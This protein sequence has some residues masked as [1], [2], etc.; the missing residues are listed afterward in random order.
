MPPKSPEKNQSIQT[1]GIRLDVSGINEF[2]SF[3]RGKL[4]CP[5]VWFEG[6]YENPFMETRIKFK[7]S[8]DEK[9]FDLDCEFNIR[10]DGVDKNAILINDTINETIGI[11]QHSND[12]KSI[13]K[14]KLIATP[15][16]S[17]LALGYTPSR[18]DSIIITTG[19]NPDENDRNRLF[20]PPANTPDNL[21]MAL[22]DSLEILEIIANVAAR[23]YHGFLPPEYVIELSMMKKFDENQ[24][25]TLGRSALTEEMMELAG[26]YEI[27]K[28]GV[29]FAD[30]GGNE[31]AK[32]ELEGLVVQLNNP[33]LCRK[34]AIKP[35]KGIVLY[36]PTGTGKTLMVKA[37]ATQTEARF[38]V[39]NSS[40]INSKWFGES[41]KNVENIFGYANLVGGKT[42]I[43]LDELDSI[44]PK[45]SSGTHEATRKVLNLL[46][47]KIDGIEDNENV[48]IVASTNRI[49]DV[50]AAFIRAGRLGTQIKVELPDIAAI[51]QIYSIHKN[52]AEKQSTGSESLFEHLD[53]D[54]LARFSA[55]FSGADIAE[56]I[57]RTLRDKFYQDVKGENPKKINTKDLLAQINRY[58]GT[59][60]ADCAPSGYL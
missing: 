48:I 20:V 14:Y 18:P 2:D 55:G 42:I 30:V 16:G 45:R 37:L 58:F 17:K 44:A 46:L 10:I 3:C 51:K 39:I 52:M 25:L 6:F 5:E 32:A 40:H 8:E 60:G 57:H 33:D 24:I 21:S 59:R 4:N 54:E 9:R 36:G 43:Y 15:A 22:K 35:Q 28:P 23:N 41:E 27:E 56:I 34:W 12:V 38:L 13:S 47:Q 29:S 26:K 53:Y 1:G 49:E 7:V 31:Q 19:S 50:D 11:L